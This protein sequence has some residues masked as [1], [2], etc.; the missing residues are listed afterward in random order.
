MIGDAGCRVLLQVLGYVYPA[1]LCFKDVE[2]GGKPD[3]LKLWC[4]YWVIIAA[5][6][7]VQPIAD[8]FLF[9]IPFY[10]SQT[11]ICPTVDSKISH[12]KQIVSDVVTSNASRVVRYVQ[13]LL[14]KSLSQNMEGQGLRAET[15]GQAAPA[16][17]YAKSDSFKS[18]SSGSSFLRSFSVKDE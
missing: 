15:Q 8:M 5:F 12:F 13:G 9:F 1:Y 17:G 14:L 18:A 7:A 4:K 16:A 10:Y 3:K 6:T 2:G 11:G